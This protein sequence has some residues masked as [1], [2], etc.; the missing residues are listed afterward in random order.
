MMTSALD[1]DSEGCVSRAFLYI[2]SKPPTPN[3]AA[4]RAVPQPALPTTA[5]R[6]ARCISAASSTASYLALIIFY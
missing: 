4:Q 3:H 6:A 1:D 2:T 5:S